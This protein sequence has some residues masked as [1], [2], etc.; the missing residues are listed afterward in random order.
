MEIEEKIVQSYTLFKIE[1][2]YTKLC[3]YN[4]MRL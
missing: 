2:N 1:K 4:C 3:I